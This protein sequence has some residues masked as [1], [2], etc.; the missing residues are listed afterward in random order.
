M[1]RN[2]APELGALPVTPEQLAKA[3]FSGPPKDDWDYEQRDA[4]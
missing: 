1:E 4:T 2:P 3:V